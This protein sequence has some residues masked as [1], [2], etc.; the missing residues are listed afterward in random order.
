[1]AV[2]LDGTVAE[3]VSQRPMVIKNLKTWYH[4]HS[5]GG[6]SRFFEGLRRGELLATRCSNRFCTEK[7]LWLPPRCECPDCWHTMEWVAAPT[8]GKIFTHTTVQY[9]GELFRASTPCP[10]ISVAIDGV[11]TKLMSYLKVG[12]PRIGMPVRAVFNAAKPTNTILDL[13]WVPQ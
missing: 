6:W 5:Y 8:V 9:P 3:L 10:L 11:C 4:S 12:Q 1:M 2:E 13:A 7:R